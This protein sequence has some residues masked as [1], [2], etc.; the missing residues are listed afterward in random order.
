MAQTPATGN[1]ITNDWPVTFGENAYQLYSFGSATN[2]FKG[3][4]NDVRIWNV[5]RTQ[6]QLRA[7][8]DTPLPNPTTQTG[9][10]GYYIFN[11]VANKQGNTTFNVSLSGNA[12]INALNPNC[13]FIADSCNFVTPVN[14]TSFFTSEFNKAIKA[15][16]QTEEENGIRNYIIERSISSNGP[17]TAIGTVVAHNFSIWSKYSFIDNF[18][19]PNIRYFY[20]LQI[21][22]IS[23]T[24]KYS[25]IRDA[26]LKS[27]DHDI[28]VYPNPAIGLINV[29]IK[30][31]HEV[32]A[33]NV[34]NDLG[35]LLIQKKPAMNNSAIIQ[36]DLSQFVKGIYWIKINN[37][38]EIFVKKME[39]L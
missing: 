28:N 9:L 12:T 24:K 31:V 26:I 36:I 3:V 19:K 38:K 33:V 35:Q 8:M 4:I 22:E 25:L 11:D 7:Y 14:I 21:I 5:A 10:K 2:V 15:N 17:F 1:L 18:A 27:S 20:R 16:W 39:K 30:N 37:G 32:V 6:E 23:G 13:T 34:F 29:D